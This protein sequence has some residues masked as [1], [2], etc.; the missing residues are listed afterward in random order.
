[1]RQPVQ[2]ATLP[3][4]RGDGEHQVQVL[5]GGGQQETLLQRQRQLLGEALSHEPLDHHRVA[6]ANEPYRLGGG[7]HLVP[8]FGSPGKGFSG[9]HHLG[10]GDRLF[11]TDVLDGD[12]T[13]TGMV[14]L[15]EYRAMDVESCSDIPG[16]AHCRNNGG[17]GR[18]DLP[19]V[20][21]VMPATH[22]YQASAAVTRPSTPPCCGRAAGAGVDRAE[23][24]Q[25]ERDVEDD[26]QKC[27]DRG[28]S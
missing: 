4:T 13:G 21:A 18:I 26:E 9:Q 19:N 27:E 16:R 12:S 5:G 3:V 17:L 14:F 8:D 7:H 6:I 24:K 22:R 11:L 2:P 25:H 10:G 23:T 20:A 1:M 15:L 28:R